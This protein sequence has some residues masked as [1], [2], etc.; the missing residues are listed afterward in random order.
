[1]EFSAK[2]TI[3]SKNFVESIGSGLDEIQGSS[4]QQLFFQIDVRF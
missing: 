4:K 2:Y 3:L 1:L